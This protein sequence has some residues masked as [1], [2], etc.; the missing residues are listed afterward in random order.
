MADERAFGCI[1]YVS[2][3]G[4]EDGEFGGHESVA[5]ERLCEI[6]AD[7][8]REAEAAIRSPLPCGH[9]TA[10]LETYQGVGEDDD[11]EMLFVDRERCAACVRERKAVEAENARMVKFLQDGAYVIAEGA[12]VTLPSPFTIGYL[13]ISAGATCVFAENPTSLLYGLDSVV[14]VKQA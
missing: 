7:A 5:T 9:P 4:W 14:K 8:I 3:V 11:G 13:H 12:E 10:C 6:I 1:A 2:A